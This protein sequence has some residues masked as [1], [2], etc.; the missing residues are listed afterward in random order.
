MRLDNNYSFFSFNHFVLMRTKNINKVTSL[1]RSA[2]AN[3]KG[4]AAVDRTLCPSHISCGGPWNPVGNTV[5][6]GI[7]LE[8][9]QSSTQ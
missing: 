8:K 6:Q 4:G 3:L 9:K 1:E 5:N 7:A 2:L